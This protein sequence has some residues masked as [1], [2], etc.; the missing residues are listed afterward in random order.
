MTSETMDRTAV[1][2]VLEQIAAYLELS[3]ENPFRVRAFRSAART[4]G[5]LAGDLGT[6]LADGSLAAAKGIGPGTLQIIE[7]LV[8]EGRSRL[9]EE[10]HEAVEPGLVEMLGISGLGVTKVRAIHGTLGIDTI[11]DLEEAARDG[12]LAALPGF[13]QKTVDNILKGIAFL[14]RSSGF[15]LS[16]HAAQ[17]AEALRTAL[18]GLDG[19]LEAHT[20][21]EVRRRCE[22]VQQLVVVLVA[23]DPPSEIFRALQQLPGVDEFAGQ[24]DRRV[25]LRFAGGSTAQVVVTTP[26]NRGAVLV[27]ATGSEAHLA[28]LAARAAERG[29][30]LAGGALWTGSEFVPTPDETTLYQRL[31]LAFVPPEMREGRD[32]LGRCASRTPRLVERSDLRGFLHCHTHYSDGTP[33]IRELAEAVRASGYDYAGITDHSRAAAYAGGLSIADLERQWAEIDAANQELGGFRIL[34]GIESDILAEGDLDYPDS[35]L[36]GFDFIIG[37]IHSR[38]GL[39]EAA[40]TARVLRALDNPYLTILGHPTGRL[41]LSRDPYPIDLEAV[42]ERAAANRVAIEINADP[43]RLDLDWRV[44][45]RA[46]DIGVTISIGSD[47]HNLAGIANMEFGVGIARKAGMGPEEILNTR[48]A[49]AFLEFARARRPA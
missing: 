24:D 29:H 1:A 8:R 9:L 23:E 19:V 41:L 40:M 33:T 10:L 38:F 14:R 25:T 16:H 3:G 45:R 6:A 48:S 46:R 5:G 39:T 4:V 11:P 32:E 47:A 44:L 35:V 18:A 21:G 12:R 7:E 37:S 13:G 36:A 30:S 49:D 15:R 43:H 2:H 17:E 31:G 22:V 42:F 27:Q 34:K 26:V 20:A 28:A